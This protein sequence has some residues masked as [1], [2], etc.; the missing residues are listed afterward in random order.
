[1][2]SILSHSKFLF[3]KFQDPVIY[4]LVVSIYYTVTSDKGFSWSNI[5]LIRG[6]FFNSCHLLDFFSCGQ[7]IIC[8]ESP[9][10]SDHIGITIIAVWRTVIY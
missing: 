6:V 5:R 10:F 7:S 8:G 3:Y 2:S 9:I 4:S 1:M